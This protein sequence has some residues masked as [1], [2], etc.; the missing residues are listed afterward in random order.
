LT[1]EQPKPLLLRYFCRPE[2]IKAGK[3]AAEGK[4]G[5]ALM[6]EDDYTT[7]GFSISIILK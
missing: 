4:Q 1:K 3:Y 5:I 6:T 2:T 7:T